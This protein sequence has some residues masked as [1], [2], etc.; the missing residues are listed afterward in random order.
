MMMFPVQVM[1]ELMNDD[2]KSVE[3]S[4]EQAI[5]I[6]FDLLERWYGPPERWYG[7]LIKCERIEEEVY[8]WRI[9]ESKR[10]RKRFGVAISVEMKSCRPEPE[11]DCDPLRLLR[12]SLKKGYSH[13]WIRKS[14]S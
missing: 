12:H 11:K 13:T 5:W 7:M 4:M 14:R 1:G 8:K 10:C 3:V 2:K 6:G 9:V